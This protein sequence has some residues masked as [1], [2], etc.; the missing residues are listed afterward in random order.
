MNQVLPLYLHKLPHLAEL[1][2]HFNAGR[3]LNRFSDAALWVELEQERE[4]YIRLFAALGYE[5]RIDERGFAWFHTD[6]ASS[7]VSKTTRQ[8]ALLFMLI[9]EYQADAGLNL[10]RFTEWALDAALLDALIEKNA[11]LLEAEELAERERLES[12]LRSASNYGFALADNA[13][14]YLQ[15]AVFRYLDH[16]EALAGRTQTAEEGSEPT[17]EP[18]DPPSADETDEDNGEGD[19]EAQP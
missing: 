5:L 6:E 1:F 16:F 3:H 4:A 9:F 19:E 13:R 14:W 7:T 11:A 17:F 18:A 2:S 15:P 8:L 12:L 10:G